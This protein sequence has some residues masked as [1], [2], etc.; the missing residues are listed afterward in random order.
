MKAA[1]GKPVRC[2]IYNESLYRHGLD[3]SSTLSIAQYEAA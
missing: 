3:Q 2:A 1:L